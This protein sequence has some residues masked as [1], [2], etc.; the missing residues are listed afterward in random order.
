[1]HLSNCGPRWTA[2]TEMRTQHQLIHN[3]QSTT[4]VL[5]EEPLCRTTSHMDSAGSECGPNDEKPA[6]KHSQH[7]T[8]TAVT[9]TFGSS[10]WN[11]RLR[12][13]PEH[14]GTER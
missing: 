10:A 11:Y 13:Q 12:M 6:T 14:D 4:T 7:S 1:M 9:C 3:R 5:P 2:V 8:R